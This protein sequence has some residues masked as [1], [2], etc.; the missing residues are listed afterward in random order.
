MADPEV[1]DDPGASAPDLVH[2][3]AQ[4][5]PEDRAAVDETAGPLYI[6]PTRMWEVSELREAD[7]NPHFMTDE[8]LGQLDTSLSEFGL[9]EDLVVNTHPD[10]HGVVVGG[11]KRL[12]L[13]KAKGQRRLPGKCVFLTLERER[14]LN[15]RLN[16]NHGQFDHRLMAEGG[17]TREELIAW[18]FPQQDL[19]AFD[20]AAAEMER[21]IH[22]ARGWAG[23]D[24]DE[25]EI[26]E[27]P[28]VPKSEPGMIY[29]LGRH[30]L[31][32]GDCR[33]TEAMLRLLAG[34]DVALLLTDPPYNVAYHGRTEEEMTIENDDMTPEEYIA[35]LRECFVSIDPF[36]SPGTPI[37]IWHASM[38]AREV[39]AAFEAVD[40][41]RAQQLIWVKHRF[42]LGR[43]DY[44][45]AH[46]PC[47][48]GWKKGAAHRWYGGR[49]KRTV[50][51][52]PA[53]AANRDHPTM[54][55]VALFRDLLENST[56]PEE[57]AVD[58]FGGSGT[59]VLACE[60]TSRTALVIEKD[61]RYADVIR[62]RWF[63]LTHPGEPGPWEDETP[64]LAAG[65]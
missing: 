58:L 32:V 30:R 37:Y 54:K 15:A 22:E 1:V 12:R 64:A 24:P 63:E 21:A 60:Q 43:S 39:Q 33:D 56:R 3:E 2:L 40:W 50:L 11:H 62:R 25:V 6:P 16:A 18:G 10:R 19:Q 5:L 55:P 38:K 34:H 59:L 53:P 48:Y 41:Y 27:P 8:Q 13:A 14:E 45:W 36:L 42:V 49:D 17:Y 28:E 61:P 57:V 29:Q 31:L 46:E 4:S 52:H 26:P 35:F 9:V 44:H 65:G 20:E 47:F 23:P 51:E 7:Y